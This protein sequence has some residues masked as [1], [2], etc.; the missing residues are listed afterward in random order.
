MAIAKTVVVRRGGWF[1][2]EASVGSLTTGGAQ[3]RTEMLRRRAKLTSPFY[4]L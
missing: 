2:G 1:Q 4:P 3:I